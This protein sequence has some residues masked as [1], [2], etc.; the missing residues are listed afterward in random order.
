MQKNHQVFLTV[1]GFI[2]LLAGIL[3]YGL[4]IHEILPVP[5]PNLVVAATS[6]IG[7]FLIVYGICDLFIK[8]SSEMEIEAKDERN[9][10]LGNAA[11]ASGFK[12]MSVCLAI[13]ICVLS[14]TGYITII[15]CLAIIGAYAVGQIAFIARLY[16]LHKTM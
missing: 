4:G 8:K 16:Y 15:P 12:V 1:T 14:F 3:T 13:T 2:I 11:M 10:A 6:L 7:T 9:I 5:R